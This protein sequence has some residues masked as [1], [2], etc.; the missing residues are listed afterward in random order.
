MANI[1]PTEIPSPEGSHKVYIVTWD[2]MQNGDV[3]LPVSFSQYSD[4]SVQ[5]VGTLAGG[6]VTVEGSLDGTN[7]VPLTDPQGNNLLIT[8]SKI[9]MITELVRFLRPVI[10][11]GS[12]ASV[13]VIV[14]LRLT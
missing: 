8:T 1:T 9:E 2:N 13:K 14:L 6:S 11:S 4:R 10:S 3:G 12:G 7:Y 5:V